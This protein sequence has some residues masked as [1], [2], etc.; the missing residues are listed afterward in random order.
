MA[1][2]SKGRSS[3]KS[4]AKKSTGHP[5]RTRP[6]SWLGNLELS[7]VANPLKRMAPQWHAWF[8]RT[9]GPGSAGESGDALASAT[10]LLAALA[11]ST[12]NLSVTAYTADALGKTLGQMGQVVEEVDLPVAIEVAALYTDFLHET[13]NWSGSDQEYAAVLALLDRLQGQ[14]APIGRTPKV[15][16]AKDDLAALEDIAAIKHA[17]ALL[18]W[19]G[20]GV[21]ATGTGAI[22]LRDISPAAAL[23]GVQ[24]RV[25]VAG[26]E[27]DYGH[28]A[29][30]SEPDIHEVRS[31]REVPVLGQMWQSMLDTGIL[32]ARST[33]VVPGPACETFSGGT[34]QAQLEIYRLF[35]ATLLTSWLKDLS[36]RLLVGNFLATALTGVL[37][38]ALAG[39]PRATGTIAAASLIGGVLMRELRFLE[40]L[41]LIVIDAHL[42]VPSELVRP[43]AQALAADSEA[44]L[45]AAD[46]V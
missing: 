28:L 29:T 12:G 3:K 39:R 15:L 27:K 9:Q 31:M 36:G 37:A 22:R 40:T 44:R 26:E 25:L 19:V 43:H 41:G 5:G 14:D 20:Q 32:E 42:W 8:A 34:A 13:G 33:K 11:R 38:D 21:Q 6:T 18:G 46:S 10:I 4:P 45:A 2:K 23:L 17:H 7:G 35:L 16:S 1:K 30:W 24:A